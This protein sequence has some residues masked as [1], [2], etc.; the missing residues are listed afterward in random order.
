MQDTPEAD[1]PPAE[2]TAEGSK[3]PARRRTRA[4][5]SAPAA[6]IAAE[7]VA[8]DTPVAEAAGETV[9]VEAVPVEAVPAAETPTEEPAPAMAAATPSAAEP[10]PP[11]RVPESTPGAVVVE[12]SKVATADP[13]AAVLKAGQN[14]LQTQ[15]NAL[16]AYVTLTTQWTQ[17]WQTLFG[18]SLKLQQQVA[19]QMMSGLPDLSAWAKKAEKDER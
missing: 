4:T 16:A 8:T 19:Q 18:A 17:H 10:A 14:S 1:V 6:P 13:M 3:P 2:P 5:P 15:S 7:A 9:P 12:V 11:T